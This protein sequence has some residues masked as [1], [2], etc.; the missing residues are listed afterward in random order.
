MIIGTMPVGASKYRRNPSVSH[1]TSQTETQAET[2]RERAQLTGRCMS[3]VYTL[4]VKRTTREENTGVS[5][6]RQGVASARQ[7]RKGRRKAELHSGDPN[8]I[9]F[10]YTQPSCR[11][12]LTTIVP[13]RK[14][15]ESKEEKKRLQAQ[16]PSLDLQARN[17]N[18]TEIKYLDSM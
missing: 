11:L 3:A 10:L 4:R 13:E 17:N 5:T 14:V 8:S 6:A 2:G 12:A 15:A 1:A 7:G 18:L 16:A 9:A